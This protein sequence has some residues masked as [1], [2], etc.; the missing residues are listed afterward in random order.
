MPGPRMAISA[1][2][3]GWK[4]KK[5]LPAPVKNKLP[6]KPVK[7]HWGTVRFYKALEKRAGMK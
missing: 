2:C 3:R 4:K 1:F 5:G 7:R 6:R